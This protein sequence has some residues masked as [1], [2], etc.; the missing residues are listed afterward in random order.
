MINQKSLFNSFVPDVLIK[1]IA[2]I[3]GGFLPEEINPHIDHEREPDIVRDATTGKLVKKV[4]KPSEY[5]LGSEEE[6]TSLTINLQ[7]L[8]KEKLGKDQVTTWFGEQ[9]FTKYIKYLVVQSSSEDFTQRYIFRDQSI[10]TIDFIRIWK[11]ATNNNKTTGLQIVEGSLSKIDVVSNLEQQTFEI[12]E[13]G[14]KIFNF[15]IPVSFRLNK[16]NIKHLSYFAMAFLDVEQLVKDYELDLPEGMNRVLEGNVNSEIVIDNYNLVSNSFVFLDDSGYVWAGQVHFDEF[17]NWKTGAE[18]NEDE[19]SLTMVTVPNS[20]VQDF[21]IINEIKKNQLDFSLLED[22]VLFDLEMKLKTL[23]NTSQFINMKKSYFTKMFISRD[24]NG[25][26]RFLFGL[27]CARAVRDNALFGKLY[28]SDNIELLQNIRI[29]SLKVYRIRVSDHKDALKDENGVAWFDKNHEPPELIIYSQETEPGFFKTR[30]T[31]FGSLR[32]ISLVLEN[33]AGFRFFTGVD[34]TLK[35][36]TYGVY[37]YY[38]E[39][40]IEDQTSN[41]ISA[42][43]DNL[44][45]ASQALKEY[46]VLG[47]VPENFNAATNKFSKNFI[48]YYADK[49][50]LRANN[51]VTNN[52]AFT[53]E[54]AESLAISELPWN[55]AISSY[56]Y[57]MSLINKEYETDKIISFLLG[58]LHPQYGSLEGVEIFIKLI[59]DLISRL[60]NVMGAQSTG[61]SLKLLKSQNKI[62]NSSIKNRVGNTSLKTFV[63][64]KYFNE[65][66]DSEFQKDVGYDFLSLGA[67]EEEENDDGLKTISVGK[68]EARAIKETLKYYTS[69]D[70]NINIKTSKTVYTQNDLI[71]NNMYSYITPS[72]LKLGKNIGFLDQGSNLHDSTNYVEAVS[73]IAK[74]NS[75]IQGMRKPVINNNMTLEEDSNLSSGEQIVASNFSSLLSDR[76]VI[77]STPSK[78]LTKQSDTL[79]KVTT[80]LGASNKLAQE[81]TTP[82]Q[83]KNKNKGLKVQENQVASG[84]VVLGLLETV[85]EGDVSINP[86]VANKLEKEKAID[87]IH[88]FD[89]KKPNNLLDKIKVPR[90]TVSPLTNSDYSF[91]NFGALQVYSSE[92]KV[93]KLIIP[94]ANSF[95]AN[96]S[97]VGKSYQQ[98]INTMSVSSKEELIKN[99]PNQIKSVFV[100]SIN[101]RVVTKNW[102]EKTDSSLVSKD[103]YSFSEATNE[104]IK[105]QSKE[106]TYD[107]LKNPEQKIIFKMN[108]N[109][110]CQVDVLVGF[111]ASKEDTTALLGAPIWHLMNPVIFNSA[112]GKNLLCRLTHYINQEMG[113]KNPQSFE[114]PIYNEY[115]IISPEGEIL[116]TTPVYLA[117]PSIMQKT[118][119]KVLD[120][121]RIKG[122]DL[123]PEYMKSLVI[124]K[125]VPN[126]I[127]TIGERSGTVEDIKPKAKVDPSKL[128]NTNVISAI[129]RTTT[130]A[131]VNANQMTISS[132]AVLNTNTIQPSQVVKV[133][134]PT[135]SQVVSNSLLNSQTSGLLVQSEELLVNK[136]AIITSPPAAP[137]PPAGLVGTLASTKIINGIR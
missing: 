18:P 54:E 27:D 80:I 129:S 94:S 95:V 103:V 57:V 119:Q 55:K 118:E 109:N 39:M 17:G 101:P 120:L 11:Q 117:E 1:E 14:S 56:S 75:S 66:F 32:E 112:N 97:F 98:N 136:N 51:I 41:F 106:T 105:E 110:I 71:K 115:F 73:K 37:Q 102:F 7:I 87:S 69:V 26:A 8:I 49:V 9:D 30:K 25:N 28:R 13:E 43:I 46:K 116:A 72:S 85:F 133:N 16:S 61:K 53:Y 45:D 76:N 82:A 132:G 35:S 12:D 29:R 134:V 121:N 3:S 63:L 88:L 22:S 19:I 20:K 130:V 89:V 2:L 36:V 68:Y 122:V 111:E 90:Q 107:I 84:A 113:V 33:A 70:A 15:I 64:K 5:T 96:K 131:V 52:P 4:L 123:E 21:R 65:Q 128:L 127:S 92:D 60:S 108:Y 78:S 6:N 83:N 91:G 86:F 58:I 50:T 125:T 74:L 31:S 137:M 62:I 42:L 47:N 48:A 40:E 10:N 67:L 79:S 77:I 81:T 44:V 93:N 59:D 99:L 126:V 34:K 38:V 124:T 104:I 24:S 114:L 100:S 23:S 135:A